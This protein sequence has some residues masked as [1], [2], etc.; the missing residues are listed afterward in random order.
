MLAL[1]ERYV[2]DEGG[3]R[4]GVLLDMKSYRKILE[5]IE[6]LESIRAYDSAKASGDVSIPFEQAVSEI[7]RNRW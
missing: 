4:M 1:K 2:T 7:D 3:H 5:E 6:E